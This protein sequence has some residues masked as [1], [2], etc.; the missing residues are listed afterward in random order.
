MCCHKVCTAL[1]SDCHLRALMHFSLCLHLSLPITLVS[2]LIAERTLR[3][4]YWLEC[5]FHPPAL[6]P[7]K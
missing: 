7:H 3:S 6:P 2:L 5:D 1:L 4:P